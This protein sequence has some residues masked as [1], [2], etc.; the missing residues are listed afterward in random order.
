MMASQTLFE[1]AVRWLQA[2]PAHM[3]MEASAAADALCAEVDASRSSVVR[4]LGTARQAVELL[5]GACV[6]SPEP[7]AS[8]ASPPPALVETCPEPT[9]VLDEPP[10]ENVDLDTSDDGSDR[11]R[12]YPETGEYLFVIKGTT[13]DMPK[14][15]VAD[16]VWWFTT[17]GAHKSKRE[18]GRLLLQNHG[19]NLT[20]DFMARMLKLLGITKDSPPWAPH[21]LQRYT[22]DELAK[23]QF[24]RQQAEVELAF[25]K[26]T[27][28][29]YKKR[30]LA[31]EK[32]LLERDQLVDALTAA[33]ESRPRRAIEPVEVATTKALAVVGLYDCHIGKR[34]D[35]GGLEESVA[36]M[37]D[38]VRKLAARLADAQPPK[39]I[40]V[41][42][43]GDY[44]HI[45]GMAATTTAGT[46]QDVDASA[47]RILAAAI[48]ALEVCVDTL[49][50][51]AP[52]EVV[53]IPG[54]HDRMLAH[55]VL[56]AIARSYRGHERVEVQ[57][58]HGTRAYVRYGRC[59]IGFEH[60][61][62]PKA[63][64]L[65]SIMAHERAADWGAT[66][67]RG[68]LVGHLHHVHEREVAGC[69]VLQA[70]SLA[71]AD[72]WHKR[73]GYVTSTRALRAY[74]F[75]PL[76]GAVGQVQVTA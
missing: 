31:A 41:A 9:M 73:K 13:F 12:F 4:T 64:D 34:S 7:A 19:R 14:E 30:W 42:V 61:D 63:A 56:Q 57:M 69:H 1:Q 59:L 29:E 58:H 6:P 5:G 24:N 18:V 76:E 51:L 16:M 35:K 47:P 70:P 71:G 26:E 40:V 32:R 67:W 20:H 44:L 15:Q 8:T 72:A 53:I 65:A 17:T 27:P 2:D 49:A 3:D 60:G 43:G 66:K 11:W 22:P 23:L 62:G 25:S 38:A 46:P 52:V 75:D 33:L 37:V 21:D 50:Q 28:R 10:V 55:A 48:D 54:N 39:R 36:V 74:L 68:W 45:D